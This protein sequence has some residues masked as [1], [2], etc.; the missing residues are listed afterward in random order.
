[1]QAV[2][3]GITTKDSSES[4]PALPSVNNLANSADGSV[5]HK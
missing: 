4:N 3:Q 5:S 2:V 1:M